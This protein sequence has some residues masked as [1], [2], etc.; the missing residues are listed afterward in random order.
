M[1][2]H[3]S[4]IHPAFTQDYGYIGTLQGTH[5]GIYNKIFQC[6]KCLVKCTRSASTE[7][8]NGAVDE[9][10]VNVYVSAP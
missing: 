7:R 3:F 10:Q 2:F 9:N 6:L 5:S 4:I 1:T 8:H